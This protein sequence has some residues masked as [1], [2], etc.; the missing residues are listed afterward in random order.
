VPHPE[1]LALNSPQHR[2]RTIPDAS[3]LQSRELGHRTANSLQLA[4][5]FLLFA[6]ARVTDPVARDLLTEAATRISVVA[7]LHR[8]LSGHAP[9]AEVELAPFLAQLSGFIAGSTG[10]DCTVDADPLTLSG[11]VVQQLG[12]AIN[13]LAMNAA[14]HAYA[15]GESGPLRIEAHVDPGYLRVQVADRGQ[16]LQR[17]LDGLSKGLGMSIVMAIVRQLRGVFDAADDRGAV[18]TISIPLTTPVRVSRSF[19]PA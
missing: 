19:A 9:D 12:I 8:F 17:A 10:L 1:P 4:T 6:Q 7:Q 16:G 14:K 2:G 18:I 13:E 3:R 5:N 15:P 11:E